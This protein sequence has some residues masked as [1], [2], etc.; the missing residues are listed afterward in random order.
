MLELVREIA[1]ALV[2]DG[3]RVRVCVQQPLGQGVFAGGSSLA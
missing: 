3:R 2:E 1:T